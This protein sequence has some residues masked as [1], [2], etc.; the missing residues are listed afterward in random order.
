MTW[1]GRDAGDPRNR[2]DFRELRLGLRN[3]DGEYPAPPSRDRGR[4]TGRGHRHAA[5][6]RP[7][8]DDTARPDRRW[9][10]AIPGRLAESHEVVDGTSVVA[11]DLWICS[12]GRL[13][14]SASG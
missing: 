2:R 10:E 5:I 4:E 1:P 13:C 8:E 14:A 9:P 6:R 11:G 12:D 3:P 7:Q